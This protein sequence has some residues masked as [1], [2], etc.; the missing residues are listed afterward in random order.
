MG[1]IPSLSQGRVAK[2]AAEIR[3]LLKRSAIFLAQMRKL[4][5]KLN[6][7]QSGAMKRVGRVALRP[8]YGF[9]A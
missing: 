1:T 3:S 6:F 5:G 2:L 9:V 7:T 8:L 4:P